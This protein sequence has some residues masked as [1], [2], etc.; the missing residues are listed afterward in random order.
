MVYSEDFSEEG[1]KCLITIKGA[2]LVCF[3]LC[4]FERTNANSGIRTV[5]YRLQDTEGNIYDNI[6][7]TEI[8]FNSK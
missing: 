2:E 4:S 1:R 6:N 3:V 8:T 5:K 7:P